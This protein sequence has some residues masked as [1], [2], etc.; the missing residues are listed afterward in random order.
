MK[1]TPAAVKEYGAGP[2]C[3]WYSSFALA[4]QRISWLPG[5]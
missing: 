2:K 1:C 4:S 5:E 3:S